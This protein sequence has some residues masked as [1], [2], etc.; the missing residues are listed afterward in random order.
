MQPFPSGDVVVGVTQTVS[1]IEAPNYFVRKSKSSRIP[2]DLIT[3]HVMS[4]Q[5][6][7]KS[8]L[9]TNNVT[10]QCLTYTV[11]RMSAILQNY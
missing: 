11:N 5:H 3:R 9:M 10:Q 2:P 4:H 6:S 8:I 1:W 7:D